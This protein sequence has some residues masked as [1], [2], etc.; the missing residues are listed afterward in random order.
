MDDISVFNPW[1]YST[2]CNYYVIALFQASCIITRTL[3]HE[4]A[5]TMI[6]LDEF[7]TIFV[8]LQF[9]LQCDTFR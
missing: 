7:T 6:K 9:D 5:R 8:D 1:N 4:H 2:M 3:I